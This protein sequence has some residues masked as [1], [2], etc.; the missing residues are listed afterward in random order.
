MWDYFPILPN[1][2]FI[3]LISAMRSCLTWSAT[4]LKCRR[5]CEKNL[6]LMN[7]LALWLWLK[8]SFG[9]K[10]LCVIQKGR[11]IKR[12]QSIVSDHSLCAKQAL[13]GKT[14]TL[15][16]TNQGDE[17]GLFILQNTW[18]ATFSSKTFLIWRPM[19][20]CLPKIL[21]AST[22]PI[23]WSFLSVILATLKRFFNRSTECA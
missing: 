12:T 2:G 1:K 15:N 11:Q 23:F 16:N 9:N 20:Y 13:K 5:L 19:M 8:A 14:T 21:C 10:M 18:V 17:Y 3:P 22:K 7:C 6:G 4:M